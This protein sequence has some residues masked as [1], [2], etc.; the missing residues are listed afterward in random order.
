MAS[1]SSLTSVFINKIIEEF[2]KNENSINCQLIQPLL[3]K[4]YQN[5]Y[6]YLY[7][8]FTLLLLLVIMLILNYITLLYY[9]NKIM[10]AV[11]K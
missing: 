9:M 8:I 3:R 10:K 1:S 7:F 2:N 11:N 4:I 5:V 6:H